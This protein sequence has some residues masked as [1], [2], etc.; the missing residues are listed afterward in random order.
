R[1]GVDGA[2]P[3]GTTRRGRGAAARPSARRRGGTRVTG[4]VYLVGAGPGDPRLI[5]L[6]GAEVLQNADVLVHDRLVSSALLGLAP[7]RAERVDVGKE[8]A[9]VGAGRQEE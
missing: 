2:G 9:G 4:V 5:T 7:I 1:A 3:R 8:P 6:R